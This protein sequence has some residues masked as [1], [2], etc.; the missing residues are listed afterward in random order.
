MAKG[1]LIDMDGVVY[2]GS[3]MIPGAVEFV[4][5]LIRTDTP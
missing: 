3:Q 2:R 5:Q 4:E 1:F